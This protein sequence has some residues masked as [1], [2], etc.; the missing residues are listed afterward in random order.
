MRKQTGSYFDLWE[1]PV[2]TI[3]LVAG[4]SGLL[5]IVV[6]PSAASIEDRI[7]RK[8]PD[9]HQKRSPLIKAAVAQLNEY[10][11]GLRKQFELP[12][13]FSGLSSFS[14]DVLRCLQRVEYGQT[15]TYGALASLAGHP[16]AARAV[17]RAMAANPF[18]V[19]I[20][21]HRVLGSGGK[22]TGYSGGEGIATKQKLL[23]LERSQRWSQE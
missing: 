8:Y 9:A 21:C 23:L 2:G 22:M 11:N 13:D 6:D 12:L 14:R 3:G 7:Y 10:F 4:E 15:L 1:S 18:P 19:I 20:P 16:Q 17:G 5:E